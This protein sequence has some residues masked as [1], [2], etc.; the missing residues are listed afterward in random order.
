M[1]APSRAESRIPTGLPV[2][3]VQWGSHLCQL[4]RTSQ[5]LLEVL[6][7]FF[8]AGLVNNERCL[9]V[10]G[11]L[12]S[13]DEARDALDALV[14]DVGARLA[15]GQ[16]QIVP[17]IDRGSGIEVVAGYWIDQ[18][19]RAVAAGYRG[20]RIT[21][22]TWFDDTEEQIHQALRDER[23]VAVCCYALD[24]C[25]PDQIVELLRVHQQALMKSGGRWERIG[26]VTTALALVRPPVL[27]G[28]VSKVHTVELF[29]RHEFPAVSIAH[30]LAEALDLGHGAAVIA[31]QEHAAAIEAA[32][33]ARTDGQLVIID[34]SAVYAE[35]A[36]S[37]ST[38]ALE[39]LV[40]TPIRALI[41]RW[42]R[43]RV[44]GELVDVFCQAGDRPGAIELERWW[45]R[46]LEHLP[47]ELH[48]GYA[49]DSFDDPE[50]LRAF[51]HVCEQH[52]AVVPAASARN[53]TGRL[54][55]ELHQVSTVLEAEAARRAAF[56]TAYEGSRIAERE[57]RE[58]L[59]TLQQVTSALC[60]AAT[61]A[62]LAQV[63]AIEWPRVLGATRIALA[64]GSE[65]L[66]V[67]GITT[68]D[69]PAAIAATL[70]DHAQSWDERELAWIAAPTIAVLPLVSG[71][72]G[73]VGTLVLGFDDAGPVPMLRSLA[74]D[75]TRQLAIAV[76]RARS[77]E[78]VDRQRARAESASS[79]KDSFLAM[80]GH[81]LRNP[82]SPILT[83]T[84]LMRLRA[85]DSLIK[86]RE[87]I[88]RSVGRMIRLVD[89]LLDVSRLTRGKVEIVRAPVDLAETVTAALEQ[90]KA[91]FDERAH[92][93]RVDVAPGLSL[94]A[95]QVRLVQ[96][97]SNLLGNAAKFT[98]PGGAI[99]IE[100]AARGEL[101][102][103]SVTDNGLGIAPDLLP[104]VFDLFVQGSQGVDRSKGGLGLGLA[105]ARK[106][107]ELHGGTIRAESAGPGQG[108]RFTIAL[109]VHIPKP[110]E[111]PGPV[112]KRILVVDDNEDA[113]WLLA[114]GLRI[115]GHD[116]RVS[117]DGLA[118]LEVARGFLPEIAFLDV[119]LP[120]LD[121][122]GLCRAL[123]E[124]SVKPKTVAV[125]GYGQASDRERA[126]AAGFDLHFVKP[127]SLREMQGAI[128]ALG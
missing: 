18:A 109:P 19:E 90:T 27:H 24:R 30:R 41:K 52:A 49:V 117:H 40:A 124:L 13:V 47:I 10:T 127:V 69:E 26:S 122:Y 88:E 100:A 79:A 21:G 44:Y 96:V 20:L 105:I 108:S 115:A 14:P 107:V 8:A 39:A 28:R 120:G 64:V 48:C 37:K 93:V 4:Y 53:G 17:A 34:A 95:D 22:A 74:D 87:I 23:I 73:R 91:L 123:L 112:A 99:A 94:L 121:G 116:V 51:R 45:N 56:E 118:A 86:E 35:L 72:S 110:V 57:I 77:H 43:V 106:I 85:P 58:H 83:A 98:K 55:A 9:W 5:D 84:Q 126:R 46:Q 7:A 1:V 59:V 60:E 50:S 11:P 62:D 3:D 61:F 113:A 65:L 80:L 66:L 89:D 119:G 54:A 70:Q 6:P 82:L 81:E 12:V 67:R 75:L 36:A 114:E 97:I 104:R 68:P 78:Q 25:G 15:S 16:L 76:E 63:V 101:V 92:R 33:G 102:E 125:T 2:G 42:G 31:G 29:E 71:R 103:L 32:L 111:S 128:D 38:E